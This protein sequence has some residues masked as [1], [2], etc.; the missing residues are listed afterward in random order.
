MFSWGPA[1]PVSARSNEAGEGDALRQAQGRWECGNPRRSKRTAAVP[2]GHPWD[3]FTW[4]TVRDDNT[5][6]L[7]GPFVCRRGRGNLK[8]SHKIVAAP[9]VT[10]EIASHG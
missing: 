2:F 6:S 4:V 7:R 9:P 10:F 1:T 3:R 5:K 8:R